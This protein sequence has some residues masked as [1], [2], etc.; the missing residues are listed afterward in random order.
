[1]GPIKT[2]GK[3]AAS[4]LPAALLAGLGLPGLGALV[5]VAVLLIGLIGWIITSKDRCDRASRLLLAWRGEA[6]AL[7]PPAPAPPP[8]RTR[9]RGL[10]AHLR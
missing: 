9:P 10:F 8:P 3:A 6:S 7:V 5:L 4:V 2:A 1:M